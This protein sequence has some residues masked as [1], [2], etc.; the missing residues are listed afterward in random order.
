MQFPKANQVL[1]FWR[2]NR[3]AIPLGMALIFA[4]DLGIANSRLKIGAG[5]TACSGLR[6][7]HQHAGDWVGC[8]RGQLDFDPARLLGK[9]QRLVV[10]I[11]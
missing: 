6:L 1:K 8:G 10:R 4:G 2:T 7:Q 9:L 5:S 11:G 3:K